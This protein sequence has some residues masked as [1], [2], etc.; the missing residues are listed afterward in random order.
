MAACATPPYAR[1]YW[2]GQH[3]VFGF[4]SP[5]GKLPTAAVR[6][7]VQQ[8]GWREVSREDSNAVPAFTWTTRRAADFPASGPSLPLIRQLPQAATACVDDKVLLADVIHRSGL[9]DICPPTFTEPSALREALAASPPTALFFVKHRHGVKG[10]AVQ[11]MRREALREWLEVGKHR[12]RLGDFAVQREVAPPALWDARKFALRAHVLLS[13]R[14]A[15]EEHVGAWIHRDVIVI[16]HSAEHDEGS[17]AKDVHVSNI[18]RR[19]PPPMLTTQLPPEHP[20]GHDALWPR[21]I[22]L[23]SRCLAAVRDDLLPMSRCSQSTLY[24]V[25]AFDLALDAAGTPWLLEVNSHCALGDGTMAAVEPEVYTRL[26]ADAVGLVVLPALRDL[27]GAPDG[28]PVMP[29]AGGFVPLAW[30]YAYQEM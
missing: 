4:S 18:G 26:V 12:G 11:P 25:L 21:L 22:A 14:G 29:V 13:A 24:S 16:P 17:N 30:P 5:L 3:T 2:H 1:I 19:H 9:Q 7:L 27:D 28:A 15:N 23:T 6:S 20:A 10:K 8:H